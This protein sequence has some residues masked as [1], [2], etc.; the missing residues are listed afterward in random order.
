MASEIFISG[1]HVV[2]CYRL[3]SSSS[4]RDHS[5]SGQNPITFYFASHPFF[6]FFISFFHHLCLCQRQ[7]LIQKIKQKKLLLT[8]RGRSATQRL[9]ASSSLVD[10]FPSGRRR[11][12]F[13]F[14]YLFFPLQEHKPG[15][16]GAV[17]VRPHSVYL[18]IN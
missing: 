6:F 2:T 14:I 3:S 13:P 5:E 11:R 9:F 8:R 17:N 4:S 16:P 12:R 18:L 7:S 1:V 10:V 15:A